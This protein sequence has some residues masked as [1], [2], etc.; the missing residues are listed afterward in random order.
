MW[1]IPQHIY[2]EH[3]QLTLTDQPSEFT[4]KFSLHPPLLCPTRSKG[5]THLCL[6]WLKEILS[7]TCLDFSVSDSA[8]WLHGESRKMS[9]GNDLKNLLFHFLFLWKTTSPFT[10]HDNDKTYY[11]HLL[12]TEDETCK[13]AATQNN[14][15]LVSWPVCIMQHSSMAEFMVLDTNKS[16]RFSPSYWFSLRRTH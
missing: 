12:T 11:P 15:T 4:G 14:I 1:T 13:S 8:G 5:S 6:T 10:S 3:K 2:S 16:M 9:P 7:P